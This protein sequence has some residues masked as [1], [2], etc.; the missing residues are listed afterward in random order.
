MSR[1][2]ADHSAPYLIAAALVDGAISGETF[3][4]QRYRDKVILALTDKIRMAEDPEYTASFP[5]S[6]NCRFEITLKS[7]AALVVH[8]ENPKGHPANAMTDRDLNAKFMQLVEPI[9]GSGRSH[10]LLDVLWRLEQL[11]D[12]TPLFSLAR[13]PELSQRL[14]ASAS[15]RFA[16]SS[17]VRVSIRCI[18][19]PLALPVRIPP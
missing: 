3:T 6:M 19:P 11:K 15:T 4:P 10:E 14:D 2:T 12:M 18:T 17:Q 8:Q 9:L 13:G 16:R 7:G 1:E 5:G